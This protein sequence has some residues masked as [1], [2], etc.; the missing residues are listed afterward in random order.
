MPP[1]LR[2]HAKPL[3]L[4]ELFSSFEKGSPS[5]THV[6]DMDFTAKMGTKSKTHPGDMDFTA[7]KGT[8]SKTHPGK[9]D[10]VVKDILQ[11]KK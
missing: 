1:V 4:D 3:T 11:K 5:K 7:K 9:E 6:G 2:L 10:Y 8:K